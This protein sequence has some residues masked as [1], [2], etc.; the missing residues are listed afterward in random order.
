M[1]INAA[2]TETR[3]FRR[4]PLD[5]RSE[6]KIMIGIDQFQC[7]MITMEWSS[8]PLFSYLQPFPGIYLQLHPSNWIA[9]SYLP[10]PFYVGSGSGLFYSRHSIG[11]LLDEMCRYTDTIG[12]GPSGSPINK[13]HISWTL[14]WMSIGSS[15]HA[16]A[17]MTTRSLRL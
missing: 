11:V 2:Q 12:R 8:F 7:G 9:R 6:M 5:P 17:T 3:V 15:P 1:P 10:G 4:W 13:P 16:I 14:F